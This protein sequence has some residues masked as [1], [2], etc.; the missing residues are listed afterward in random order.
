MNGGELAGGSRKRAPRVLMVRVGAMGDVLHAMPAVAA[1]RSALPDAWIGWAVEPRWAPLLHAQSTA[2]PHMADL[3]L[4]N[5]VHLVETR[6]WSK[7]PLSFGTFRSVN[8]LRHAL[9]GERYDIAIDPQ[10]SIRSAVIAR[11]S[12]AARVVGSAHPC[13][14]PA[15]LLYTE[16]VTLRTGH[17]V[18]QAAEIVSAAMNL[19]LQP[20]PAP[21][22]V[23]AA[24]DRWRDAFLTDDPRP[25]VFLA[26]TTGWGAKQ[27]PAA[28]FGEVAKRLADKGCRVL[29]NVSP[30]GQDAVADEVLAASGGA[31]ERVACTLPHLT[32]LLRRMCLLIAGDTGPLHLAAALGVPVVAL[33]GPTDPARNGPYGTRSVVL[34]HPSSMT[35]HKRHGT[36]EAGLAKITPDE[37]VS[38]A[39]R[40][41]G[42]DNDE[43]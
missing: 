15:R 40:M 35:S 21:L 2:A 29:V 16:R 20:A 14:V 43:G 17:V 39:V 11:M 28:R 42:V 8:A 30:N 25:C 37:V 10:G 36:T 19:H 26:P 13:E 38:A 4:V 31:A 5:C 12:G 22:P 9:R 1:L 34:R 41:L 3:P 6:S 32:A 24:A 27:W 33:F 23:D 18:G 7:R